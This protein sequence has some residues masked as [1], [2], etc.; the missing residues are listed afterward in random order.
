MCTDTDRKRIS[1]SESCLL[2]MY[3]KYILSQP[4]DKVVVREKVHSLSLAMEEPVADDYSFIMY[5]IMLHTTH[6]KLLF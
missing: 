1:V 4:Y 2:Y 3:I 5:M 6:G